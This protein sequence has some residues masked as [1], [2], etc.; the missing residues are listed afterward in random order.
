MR[1][2][3]GYSTVAYVFICFHVS[4]FIVYKVDEMVAM[5]LTQTE[6]LDT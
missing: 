2:I 3:G 6:S 4:L 5:V 1:T